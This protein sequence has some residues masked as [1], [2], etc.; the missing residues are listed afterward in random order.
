MYKKNIKAYT[1]NSIQSELS[2]ADPH[3][4]IQLMMQGTLERIAQAKGA[5]ER[6]DFEQKSHAISKA[7]AIINGLIDA[8]DLSY[9]QIP[10]DLMALYGYMNERLLDASRDLD[11]N[12]LDEV[13]HLMMTIKSGWDG[14][15]AEEK[16]KALTKQMAVN[17]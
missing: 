13:A 10:T 7:M 6:R 12:A 5:I 15:S 3:R 16:S 8:L 11:V 17:S 2:V 9:G 4:V 1:T 14:I